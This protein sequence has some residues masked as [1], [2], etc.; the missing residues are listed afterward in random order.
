MAKFADLTFVAN[1]TRQ[2]EVRRK[3]RAPSQKA[4]DVI[5]AFAV[6]NTGTHIALSK[7]RVLL[8]PAALQS[9]LEECAATLKN[10]GC[11][12]NTPSKLLQTVMLTE[13]F[14]LLVHIT[15]EKIARARGKNQTK[16]D[17]G[18]TTQP[19]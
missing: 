6:D 4:H 13:D 10:L 8:T 19:V 9:D 12:I 1:I 18:D 11:Y 17:D 15:S 3:K 14:A 5:P 7:P 2:G 16:T